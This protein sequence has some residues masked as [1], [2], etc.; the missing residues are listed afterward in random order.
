MRSQYDSCLY[1]KESH[2]DNAVYLLL[3]VDDMLIASRNLS[4]IKEAKKMLSTEFDMKDLGYAKRI[5][6][7]DIKRDRKQKLLYLSQ[8]DYLSKVVQKFSMH[9]SKPVKVPL[10]GHFKLSAQQSPKTEQEKLK[11]AKIPYSSA[12]GSLM[13]S[14]ICT[15]PDLAYAVSVL[16]KYM[17]NPGLD[18]WLAMKWVLKYVNSIVNYGLIYKYTSNHLVLEGF[19]DSD[20]AGDRDRRRSTSAYMMTLDGNCIS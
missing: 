7:I 3:Y 2:T 18:H 10:A 19:V 11:M 16:S 5:L 6:G 17:A 8:E 20:F 12:V 13:Y 14:M 4:K 9:E 1:F 15:R